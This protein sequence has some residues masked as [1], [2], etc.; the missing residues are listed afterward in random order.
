M[1]QPKFF[2]YGA[3]AL[4]L[5]FAGPCAV[6]RAQ[7]AFAQYRLKTAIT[8]IEPWPASTNYPAAAWKQLVAA[9][10]KFQAASPAVA[11]AV[12]DE[13]LADKL[14]AA[15]RAGNQGK[16]FLLL[17]LAFDLSENS[18]AVPMISDEYIRGRTDLNADGTFNH[19]W[20]LALSGGPARLLAGCAGAAGG[21]Y[22]AQKEFNFLRYHF[23]NRDLAGIQF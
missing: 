6:R 4:L 22:S 18:P 16:V 2:L 8:R 10:K 7:P 5:I 21:R 17:R 12:L 14:D 23:K 11:N 15:E 20:P 19:A 13:L 1:R 3:L 9:A